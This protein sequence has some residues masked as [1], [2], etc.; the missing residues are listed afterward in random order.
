MQTLLTNRQESQ[1]VVSKLV[2][3][4]WLDEGFKQRFLSEPAAVLE[5]NGVTVPSGVRVRVNENA[6]SDT[7][8]SV[9][10]NGVY[11]ILLPAKPSGFADQK[12]QSW[13]DENTPV[14]STFASC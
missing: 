5:E 1:K 13:T 8:Q 2:A 14:A 4:A 10:S 7:A 9:E 11:E 6:S 3:Q 12:I